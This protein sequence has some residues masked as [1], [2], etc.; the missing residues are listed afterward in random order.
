MRFFLGGQVDPRWSYGL[1]I[2]TRVIQA[3]GVSG[4]STVSPSLCPNTTTTNCS[5]SDL[6]PTQSTLPLNLDY[7]FLRVAFAAR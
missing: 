3:N 7:A 5:F 4:A 6:N 2:S 1:R